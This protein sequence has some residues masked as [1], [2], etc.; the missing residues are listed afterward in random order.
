[1][2]YNINMDALKVH[3][4]K[5]KKEH[6]S[7]YSR[8]R[9]SYRGKGV[10]LKDFMYVYNYALEVMPF[11]PKGV[12]ID[13][14]YDLL[15]GGLKWNRCFL[16]MNIFMHLFCS[17]FLFALEACLFNRDNLRKACMKWVLDEKDIIASILDKT[18]EIRE[19]EPVHTGDIY[20]LEEN[21]VRNSGLLGADPEIW[22]MPCI[23]S[24][25]LLSEK[26][27]KNIL[28]L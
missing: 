21:L 5:W 28:S 6:L 26:R 19:R 4:E 11:S 16:K 9:G 22:L 17:N 10:T 2:K 23:H 15:G 1:M 7:F 27:I 25:L 3:L 20:R 18:A 14:Y 24:R 12:I 8:F 13:D